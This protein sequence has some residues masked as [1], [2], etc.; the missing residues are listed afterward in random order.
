MPNAL[1]LKFHEAMLNI[2]TRAK[3]EA[4]YDAHVFIGMVSDK[5]GLATARYL[6]DTVKPSDGYTNLWKRGRLDLTV[7]AVV[8]AP[9]WWPLFTSTQRRTA[10]QRLVDHEYSGTLPDPASV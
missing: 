5:G 3:H 6:L 10:I 9:E 2:Y 8:L 7:E 4:G 1:E